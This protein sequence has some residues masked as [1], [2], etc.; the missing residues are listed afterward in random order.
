LIAGVGGTARAAYLNPAD[1][2]ALMLSKDTQGRNL[3]GPDYTGGPSS[4]VYG[5]TLW[6]TP[7]IT[8]GTAL[9]ADPAQIVVA[10][11]SDPTVAVSADAMFTQDAQIARVIVRLDCGVNDPHGLVSIAATTREAGAGSKKS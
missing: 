11:P 5:L 2:T 10:V 1:V 6:S 3:L 7:A 9:I 8:A 4:T